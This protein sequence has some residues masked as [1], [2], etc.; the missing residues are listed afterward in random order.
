MRVPGS[1][2]LFALLFAGSAAGA[3]SPWLRAVY[4]D[5]GYPSAWATAVP[6]RDALAEAGYEVLNATQLK[7][8]MEARIYDGR[9]SVVVFSQD[10]VP[11]T[12]AE[13]RASTC[14]LRR[15]L[16]KGGKVVWFGDIPMYYQ[17]HAGGSR[18]TWD[19]G[20]A[21]SILGFTAAGATWDV[22]QPVTITGDGITWGLADSWASVRPTNAG[23][24]RVLARDVNGAAAAWVRHYGPR[25]VFRGFVR[26]FDRSGTPP[27]AAVRALAEYAPSPLPGDNLLDNIVLTFHYPWYG[28][29]LTSGSWIHWDDSNYH[30]PLT[31]TAN[32]LPNFPDSKW[33]PS[34]QLYDSADYDLLRW[35][36]RAMAR[37]GIDIAVASWWGLGD[38]PF[39]RA[40]R[41]AKS[42]QWCIYYELDSVYDPTPTEIFNHLKYVIDTHGPT[43]NYAKI[44]GKWLVAV[45]AVGG[46]EPATRWRTAKAMLTAS[47]YPI[48]LHGDVGDP[49]AATVPDP[50]DAVHVYNPVTYQTQSNTG[51]AG[52]DSGT[53]S[54]GFWGIGREP[55]LARSLPSFTAGWNTLADTHEKWRFAFIE[56]WNEWH[57]GTQI[58]PGQ[59]IVPDTVNGFS[60]AGYNYGHDFIDAIAPRAAVLRWQSEG[61]R[62]IAP[63]RLEAESMVWEVGTSAEGPTEWRISDAGARIGRGIELPQ[64]QQ[65]VWLVARARGVQSDPAADWPRMIVYWDNTPVGE[66][67][68]TSTL[69]RH[70]RATLSSMAGVHSLELGLKDESTASTDADLVVDFVDVYLADVSGDYDSD[71]ISDEVDNCPMD[72]NAPQQDLDGDGVGESCDLCPGTLAGLVVDA[73]GCPPPVRGDLDRDGDVDQADFGLLQ[74]CLN[75]SGRPYAFGCRPADLEPDGDVDGLDVESF[76]PCMSGSGNPSPC[77]QS[78]GA[79]SPGGGGK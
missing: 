31:W 55:W 4:Y 57:E 9:L 63:A 21:I 30:P 38:L 18:T 56:T 45:Y 26:F 17:G 35:Q 51:G 48:Y 15:Y 73:D 25:D 72:A 61:H 78:A 52:D 40:V 54:P 47:G 44:D 19:V 65:Q 50:W 79:P 11:D 76:R 22:N 37:A 16:N 34:V 5:A 2:C 7:T 64:A 49:S 42:V 24:L 14:T 1:Y 75:G 53:I 20:G 3:G 77:L 62:P 46:A 39:T 29:P 10:I 6:V 71:G 67:P 13:T 33:D 43:R 23:G 58:E 28:N 69:P 74:V 66:V 27:I 41:T 12:V 68:V 8:W 60:P 32:Y 70:Y 59:Q 36:D